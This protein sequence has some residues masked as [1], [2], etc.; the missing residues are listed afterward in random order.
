MTPEPFITRNPENVLRM[1][2]PSFWISDVQQAEG[3][4]KLEVA[5][6]EEKSWLH[7]RQ[8]FG[9]ECVIYPIDGEYGIFRK[10]GLPVQHPDDFLYE[11]TSI[12]SKTGK[13]VTEWIAA[14]DCDC[15]IILIRWHFFE[16]KT[17]ATST[18]EWQILNNINKAV[19]QLAKSL[20]S[21]RE[22]LGSP[23]PASCV[24]VGPRI[25][26]KTNASMIAMSIKFTKKHKAE[27][28]FVRIDEVY[29]LI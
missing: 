8:D 17:G 16:F 4:Y 14:G 13:Q 2:R 12:D 23:I 6:S 19:A 7:V 25:Y 5:F 18:G 27:L 1:S 9:D 24:V 22:Q 11:W 10:E 21:F 3:G 28:E 15:L 20:V 26:P 29:R